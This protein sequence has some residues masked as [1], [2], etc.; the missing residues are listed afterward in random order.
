MD[1]LKK[2]CIPGNRLMLFWH[3]WLCMEVGIFPLQ[4]LIPFF[5][6][7][8]WHLD[9]DMSWN[10]SSLDMSIWVWCH[11]LWFNSFSRFGK[12]FDIFSLKSFPYVKIL[13]QFLLLYL[14][15]LCLISW[16]HFWL[17]RDVPR[18]LFFLT[19]ITL[20]HT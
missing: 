14:E 19:C 4:F 20:L 3:F 1:F 10:D 16:I 5:A 18:S 7:C 11:I 6:L 2:F 15:F 17:L 12:F 9:K 8:C 13:S